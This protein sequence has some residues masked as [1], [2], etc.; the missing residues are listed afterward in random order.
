[1]YLA[2][3]LYQRDSAMGRVPA[4]DAVTQRGSEGGAQ[5]ADGSTADIGDHGAGPGLRDAADRAASGSETD[6]DDEGGAAGQAQTAEG[7]R[8]GGVTLHGIVRRTAKLADDRCDAWLLRLRIT[9]CR[10]S[11]GQL[12]LDITG[13]DPAL[14]FT[15]SN[16]AIG[17]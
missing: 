1:M 13:Y 4:T 15:M 11:L 10:P 2:L 7:A 8:D 17:L 14:A 12:E 3:P 6:S 9:T 5:R 16:P